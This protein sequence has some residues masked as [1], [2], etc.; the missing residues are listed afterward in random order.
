[1][2]AVIKEKT[3]QQEERQQMQLA[4]RK[5]EL[6]KMGKDR[7]NILKVVVKR[8]TSTN[9]TAEQLNNNIKRSFIS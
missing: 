4:S 5:D 8:Q 6:E 3:E 1:M 2:K 7:I 9:Q